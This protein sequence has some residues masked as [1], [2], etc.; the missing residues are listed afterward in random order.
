MCYCPIRYP[1]QTVLISHDTPSW[2]LW[3]WPFASRSESV[4]NGNLCAILI[5]VLLLLILGLPRWW[6]RGKDSACQCSRH[7]TRVQSLGWEDPLEQE[8]TT[9]SSI[10][11]WKLPWTEEPATVHGVAKS[12][13][14][15]SACVHVRVCVHTHTHIND[16][17]EKIP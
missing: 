5:Q 14:W 10:L 17:M 6:C 16:T 9:Y 2:W 15:L 7:K 12:Q 3:T 11:A 4:W 8:M 13:T 1:W